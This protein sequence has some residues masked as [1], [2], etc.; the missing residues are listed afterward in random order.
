MKLL[1]QHKG[2]TLIETALILLILMVIVLGLVEFA[3]AWYLKS[4]LKNAARQGARIAAVT[5]DITTEYDRPAPANK[6]DPAS[7]GTLTGNDRVFCYI[8]ISPGIRNTASA[9][10]VIT[11]LDSNTTADPDDIVTVTTSDY[12]D[13]IVGGSGPPWPWSDQTFTADATMRHE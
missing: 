13:F 10:L 2:Q 3:R 5:S 11:Q 4:S 9:T 7:C 12:F 6:P 8:W 1:K